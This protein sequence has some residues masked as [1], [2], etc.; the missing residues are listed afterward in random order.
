MGEG[1]PK[2]RGGGIRLSGSVAP[3]LRRG[4][5]EKGGCPADGSTISGLDNPRAEG[6]EVIAFGTDPVSTGQRPCTFWVTWNPLWDLS[7]HFSSNRRKKL[8]QELGKGAG[9]PR[10]PSFV[11]RFYLAGRSATP[12]PGTCWPARG[13]QLSGRLEAREQVSPFNSCQQNTTNVLFAAH[14]ISPAS[15]SLGGGLESLR[16]TK[17]ERHTT[18]KLPKK[19]TAEQDLN[20]SPNP[21]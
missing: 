21:E 18:P 8:I 20:S 15:A 5:L 13:W 9:W 17:P 2:R 12:A 16:Q 7:L 10:S 6:Q 3:S 11:S 4:P 1:A 19:A 14:L